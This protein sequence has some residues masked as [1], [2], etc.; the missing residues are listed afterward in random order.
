MNPH[1]FS[2][3]INS[4]NIALFTEGGELSPCSSKKNG[5]YSLRLVFNNQEL[6]VL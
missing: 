1:K 4:L 6:T 3:S 2:G 5:H